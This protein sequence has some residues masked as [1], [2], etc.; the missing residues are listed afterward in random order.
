MFANLALGS[1]LIAATVL[2]Q[3]FGLIVLSRS[4]PRL[5]GLLHLHRH[6]VGKTIAMI[7]TVVGLFLVHTLEV[8]IW[9]LTFVG[10]GAIGNFEDALYLSTATFSTVGAGD[11]GL[12]PAWRLLASLEGI[13]GFL[14]I[15]WSI[16]FLVA[17][18][19]RYGPF[20]TEH[21]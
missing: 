16:A 12:D 13:N 10:I 19:T 5:I 14:L 4:M 17:A 11:V 20:R 9:S 1:L 6:G 3:T 18:S 15:G 2:I 8:W 21:F 7:A